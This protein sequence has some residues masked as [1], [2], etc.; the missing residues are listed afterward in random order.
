MIFPVIMIIALVA[1]D[2]LIKFQTIARLSLGEQIQ[3]I[4]NF[5]SITYVRNE[6]AAWSILEGKMW[7][8][9]IITIIAVAAGIYFLVKSRNKSKVLTFALSLAIAGG[10]GNFIDRMRLGYVIDMFQT[11]FISFPV[12]NFADS[13][14]VVGMIILCIYLW[15]NDEDF[16]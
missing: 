1:I 3:V 14:L 16:K 5:F 9:F 2:Q 15:R 7:F 4:P 13:C 11:E 12:F 10:I 8:F 6:G